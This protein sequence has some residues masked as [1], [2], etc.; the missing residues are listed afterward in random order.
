MGNKVA[1]MTS[2]IV[3]THASIAI[4][5]HNLTH[6]TVIDLLTDACMSLPCK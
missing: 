3:C 4:K 5:M 1:S 6:H 2:Q